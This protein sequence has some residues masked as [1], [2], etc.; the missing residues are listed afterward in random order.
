MIEGLVRSHFRE[1]QTQYGEKFGSALTDL[2]R[3]LVAI[4]NRT[5]GSSHSD[6]FTAAGVLMSAVPK[7]DNEGTLASI[8]D[9]VEAIEKATLSKAAA[10]E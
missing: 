2:N 1:M 3:R 4:E 7:E 8:A 6:A 5:F 9:R 10:E